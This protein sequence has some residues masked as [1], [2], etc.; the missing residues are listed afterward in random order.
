MQSQDRTWQWSPQVEGARMT[1]PVKKAME[2]LPLGPVTPIDTPGFDDE[3][4]VRVSAPVKKTRQILAQTDLGHPCDRCHKGVLCDCDREL[5]GLF[6]REKDSLSHRRQQ[7]GPSGT[8][9]RRDRQSDRGLPRKT[10][11]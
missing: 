1:D 6:R 9:P 5:L 10:S 11:H 8:G 2:L 3:G 7:D 4:N